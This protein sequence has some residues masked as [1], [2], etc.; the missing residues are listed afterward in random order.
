M[1]GEKLGPSNKIT[2]PYQFGNRLFV[3]EKAVIQSNKT[4]ISALN[5][6][7]VSNWTYSDQCSFMINDFRHQS[8]AEK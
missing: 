1:I 4:R 5:I 3:G 8:C 7:N 2:V 6:S